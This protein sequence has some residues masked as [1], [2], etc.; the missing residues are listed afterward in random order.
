[1]EDN[2]DVHAGR[3]AAVEPS[4]AGTNT[5][6]P[7]YLGVGLVIK[8]EIIGDEDLKIDGKIEGPISL[9]NH[10][11]TAG[12]TADMAGDIVAREI[13]V[14]GNVKGKLSGHDRI[15]L[16]KNS[17]VL[18]SLT[19]PRIIIEDGAYFK[20]CIEIERNV[21]KDRPDPNTLLALAEKDFKMKS[22]RSADFNR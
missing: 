11:L 15:E 16:K 6:T 5:R 9:G 8:G 22:V 12:V 13:M 1:M 10:R 19:T 14:Y 21:T 3:Q 2:S 7:S 17:S 4:S 20:G 18:G